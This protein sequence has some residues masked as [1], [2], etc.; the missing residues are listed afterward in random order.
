MAVLAV[1]LAVI[2]TTLI[3]ELDFLEGRPDLLLVLVILIGIRAEWRSA[4][5]FG[6]TVGVLKDVLSGTPFGTYSI[7]YM[8]AAFL[9]STAAES[10]FIEHPITRAV[11]SFGAAIGINA[12]CILFTGPSAAN[13]PVY[14]FRAVVSSLFAPLLVLTFSSMPGLRVRSR[15]RV[16]ARL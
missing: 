3:G 4:S 14:A 10:T 2:Q 13:L 7:L 16:R 12:A 6:W 8:A 1:L 5:I 11:L 15:A 9:C